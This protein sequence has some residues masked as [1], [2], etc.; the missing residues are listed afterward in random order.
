MA[1]IKKTTKFVKKA[2]A[3][4]GFGKGEVKGE[5]EAKGKGEGKGEAEPKAAMPLRK[6]KSASGMPR[7]QS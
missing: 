5:S 6:K 2:G 3:F 7:M 1:T 4:K